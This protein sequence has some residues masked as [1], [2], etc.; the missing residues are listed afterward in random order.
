MHLFATF[1]QVMNMFWHYSF[2]PNTVLK[3]VTCILTGVLCTEAL[4]KSKKKR[5]FCLGKSRSLQ[6]LS[7]TLKPETSFL[8]SEKPNIW[9][10]HKPDE[11]S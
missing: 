5:H 4:T 2:W 10:S 8:S 6:R 9:A 1:Q 3:T 7:V 11:H